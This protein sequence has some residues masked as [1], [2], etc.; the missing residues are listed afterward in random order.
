VLAAAAEVAVTR[1]PS[2]AASTADCAAA[3]RG[4]QLGSPFECATSSRSSRL[5]DA[6]WI[7]QILRLSV[8]G[9]QILRVDHCDFQDS[10]P[11]SECLRRDE[12]MKRNSESWKKRQAS[13]PM[14]QSI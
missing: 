6:R 4:Y 12:T 3:Y 5:G 13:I 14:S 11:F 9:M 8:V 7:S 1:V 10:L 2:A